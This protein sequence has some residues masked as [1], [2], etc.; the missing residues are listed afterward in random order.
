MATTLLVLNDAAASA[1]KRKQVFN[2][3]YNNYTDKSLKMAQN[4]L[5]KE[6]IYDQYDT[7]S[8]V[9]EAWAVLFDKIQNGEMIE[10]ASGLLCEII[11]MGIWNAWRKNG[12]RNAILGNLFDEN[13]IKSLFRNE[14]EEA[15]AYKNLLHQI[16]LLSEKCR[17][18]F[19]YLIAGCSV[20]EMYDELVEN[21]KKSTTKDD[22]IPENVEKWRKTMY[23]QFSICRTT[24]TKLLNKR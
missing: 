14:I 2:T 1:E 16:S 22:I 20:T 7:E 24:L 17:K 21:R 9:Q 6:G 13:Y 8:V 3:F 15:E 4:T 19:D 23:V 10:N 18:M 12:R 5:R 11:K